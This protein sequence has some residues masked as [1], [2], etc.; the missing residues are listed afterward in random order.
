[1]FRFKLHDD[2]C[3][4][5]KINVC[6]KLDELCISATPTLLRQA[7]IFALTVSLWIPFADPSTSLKSASSLQFPMNF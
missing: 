7:E 3:D 1:M 2:A 4:I 6:N 5:R